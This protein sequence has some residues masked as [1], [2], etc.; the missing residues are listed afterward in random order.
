MAK[1]KAAKKA[2]I[3]AKALAAGRE[4]AKRALARRKEANDR[5]EEALTAKFGAEVLAKSKLTKA[6]A[7]K[8]PS[9]GTLV[10]EGD[11][12]FDYPFYDILSNLDQFGYDIE[13]VAHMGD[14][15]EDMAYGDGQLDA[16][17]QVLDKVLRTGTR[18][19][20]ILL[21]GGGN[22]I[23]GDE[24]AILLNHADSSIAGINKSIVGG[25]IEER[26]RDAYVRILTAVTE[27]CKGAVGN[28]VPIIM[29]GYDYSVPDG[30][31]YAGGWGPLPGPWLEPSFRR[32]GY[33]DLAL[34][35]DI[36]KE[37]IN[38]FNAMLKSLAGK[39]PF[40]HVRYLNL[41]ETLSTGD[42]YKAFWGNELHPTSDGFVMVARKF[43][44]EIKKIK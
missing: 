38:R 28:V 41:R 27:V 22:D 39:A 33:Q 25:L 7:P 36:V 44:A 18:P 9:L 1:K 24:F 3:S 20:A 16:F 37:L 15:V 14:T 11:S 32:K 13:A 17:T 30:R 31:G 12:W 43:E 5:R 10:A 4:A 35:K 40:E 2:K 29:H 34:R 6:A 21:S 26:L 19:K 23:A 42:D 8:A